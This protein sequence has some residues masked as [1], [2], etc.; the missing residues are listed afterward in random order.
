[1]TDWPALLATILDN[2]YDPWP[3]LVAADWLEEQGDSDR[4]EF[5]RLQCSPLLRQPHATHPNIPCE[6]GTW[7]C[8]WCKARGKVKNLLKAQTRLMTSK[9]VE[10]WFAG[11]WFGVNLD[12]VRYYAAVGTNGFSVCDVRS[13]ARYDP[14]PLMKG[15]FVRGFVGTVEL[16]WSNW[17]RHRNEICKSQPVTTVMLTDQPQWEYV[18]SDQQIAI[19]FPHFAGVKSFDVDEICPQ[20]SLIPKA[21]CEAQWP[22]IKFDVLYAG[23]AEPQILEFTVNVGRGDNFRIS[24][25]VIDNMFTVQRIRG[26]SHEQNL[27]VFVRLDDAGDEIFVSPLPTTAT[28]PAERRLYFDLNLTETPILL[29]EGNALSIRRITGRIG[30]FNP[31]I[32]SVRWFGGQFTN[33]AAFEAGRRM[34]M[35]REVQFL[36]ALLSNR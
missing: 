7:E 17:L 22:G 16:S 33:D 13:G 26:V 32:L 18:D 1:M 8:D 29:S 19:L 24:G 35:E 23:P 20:G 34:A 10:R 5:I 15:V 11:P 21:L 9:N 36:E 27:G 6:A 12:G 4:A 31:A 14:E 2:P 25:V 28:A 3:R 30:E